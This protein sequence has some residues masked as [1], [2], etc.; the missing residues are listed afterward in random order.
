MVFLVRVRDSQTNRQALKYSWES[1][2]Y[3]SSRL[4]WKSRLVK[5][6]VKIRRAWKRQRIDGLNELNVISL[7]RSAMQRVL[8]RS[9]KGVCTSDSGE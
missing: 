7:G 9:D 3:A 1:L 8:F 5:N 4:E 6:E 2:G